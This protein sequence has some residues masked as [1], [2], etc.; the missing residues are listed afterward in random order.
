M[1]ARNTETSY[2]SGSKVFHWLTAFLVICLVIIGFIMGGLPLTLKLQ[3]YNLH[4]S[5]GVLVLIL[6]L[7]RVCWNILSRRPAPD[8]SLTD[9]EKAAS[10]MLHAGFYVLLIAMPLSGWIMS[11]AAGR[12][13]SF[14]GLFTLPDLVAKDE[15]TAKV[16]RALHWDIAWILIAC[17]V[18]HV[19]AAIKH[20]FVDKDNV[21]RRMLPA[22]MA[23]M[24]ISTPV[25]AQPP[26]EEWNV[27][28]PK[29]SITFRPTQMGQEFTGTFP[30]FYSTIAFDPEQLDRSHAEIK[31]DLSKA[32]TGAADR[33]DALQGKEWFDVTSFPQAVFK[34]TKFRK[35][36]V[37]SYEAEGTLTI[38]DITL[39]IIVPFHL[40]IEKN[41]S[42]NKTATMNGSV[43]LDRSKFNLGTGS[44]ADPTAIANNVPVDIHL[45]AVPAHG[46]P[47]H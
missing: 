38:K 22:L 46:P 11:S 26:V 21:L 4:K 39:P 25:S 2:G 31:I 8:E 14:F 34:T 20:H 6:T 35:T 33:D 24:L 13:V 12:P 18:L 43:I 29:S 5:L 41:D 23:L 27:L 36:G 42:G 44:W 17:V 37:D 9:F 10:T 19:S 16:F 1:A 7:G 40:V 3:T 45:V 47:P 15:M 28:R 32:S 30:L